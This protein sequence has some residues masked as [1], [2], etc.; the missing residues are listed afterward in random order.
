M[1]AG[2]LHDISERHTSAAITSEQNGVPKAQYDKLF[3]SYSRLASL[4]SE[5]RGAEVEEHWRRHMEIAS[6]ALLKGYERTQVR[7]IMY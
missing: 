4:V 7:D 2:M 5:S 3:R 6:T 1:I